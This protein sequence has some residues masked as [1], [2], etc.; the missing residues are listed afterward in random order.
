[1]DYFPLFARLSG[2]RCLVV[3]GGDVALRKIRLLKEAGASITVVAPEL[4]PQVQQMVDA[5]SI[6]HVRSQYDNANLD[7]MLLVIAATNSPHVNAQVFEEAERR[8]MLSNSVDD[9]DNSS[10]ITPAIVDRSPL[11]IAI[12][13]GG[14]APVLARMIREKLERDPTAPEWIITVRSKGYMFAVPKGKK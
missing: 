13:S 10:F 12:S 2:K 5:A 1:M 7:G 8:N 11:V 4:H 14:A 3:G 6:N 9:P